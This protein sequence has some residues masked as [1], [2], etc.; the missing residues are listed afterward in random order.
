MQIMLE[1]EIFLKLGVTILRF[2]RYLVLLFKCTGIN[3]KLLFFYFSV[4]YTYIFLF[5][6]IESIEEYKRRNFIEHIMP[7]VPSS[8]E[9]DSDDDQFDFFRYA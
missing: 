7:V 4:L 5:F 6:I 3:Y 9:E 8:D 2:S 1:R